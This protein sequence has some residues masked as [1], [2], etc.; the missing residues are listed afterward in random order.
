MPVCSIIIPVFN[1]A[2]V[3]RACLNR[4]LQT[5]DYKSTEII[6][7]DDGSR[8]IT[9]R[10]LRG[11][12]GLIKVVTQQYNTGFATACNDGA[13]SASGDFLVM[14]NNDTLP[15]PR[16]LDV[17]VQCLRERPRAG[18]AGSRLLFPDGTIQHAGVTFASNGFPLHIYYGFPGEHPAV[19][20]IRRYQAVTGAC[21]MVRRSL[22][23]R[24]RG[25][26]ASFHNCYEDVDL[27]LRAGELGAEVYYC[28]ES[29]LYH[30][31]SATRAPAAGPTSTSEVA[32][33]IGDNSRNMEGYRQRWA[34]RVRSDELSWYVED[35][36]LQVDGTSLYPRVLKV[37]P[38]I[39]TIDGDERAAR[40]DG[41]LQDRAR[42]AEAML[43]ENL[44]LKLQLEA[45][46]QQAM[47]AAQ[48]ADAA[49][50]TS[51]VQWHQRAGFVTTRA[52]AAA[53]YLEGNGLE[54]GALHSPMPL[55]AT[56]R[57]RYVDRM[58][59]A[60]LRRQYPELDGHTLIEPDIIAD[61]ERLDPIPDES[62]DFVVASHFLEHCQD[63][64]GALGHMLRVTRPGGIV[65]LAVPDKRFTFDRR[66]PVTTFA[67]LLQDHREG[68]EGSKRAHFEEWATLAED[69]NIR[70]RTAQELIDSDYSIHFHVW[71]QAEFLELLSRL[72]A[73]LNFPFDV[74]ATVKNGIE[75]IAILRKH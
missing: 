44:R 34:S 24:L 50:P 14:L 4:L 43:T 36:L 8:D 18:I 41:L 40:A 26:D 20:K 68:P 58:P 64:I 70:H 11:Y 42:Q 5:V 30:L 57:A 45:A 75:L 72:M 52:R 25:F 55:P 33:P 38:M 54:I 53:L 49:L 56:A 15:E 2:S 17:L 46:E 51:W 21:L 9:P 27:C 69:E 63:P 29:V 60:E 32:D 73:E 65:F 31:Q 67:H 47:W 6:V 16:W 37:S 66:R 10:M 59:V 12:D 7:V 62:Q 48:P 28:P 3:T 61:G 71:T 35:G 19:M 1:H 23:E 13:L 39:A 74:E 22:F